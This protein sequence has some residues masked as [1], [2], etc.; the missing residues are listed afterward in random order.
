MKK[1]LLVAAIGVAGLLS[2][3]PLRTSCNKVVEL[4]SSY[5]NQLSDANLAQLVADVNKAVCGLY[6]TSVTVYLS[7]H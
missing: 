1:L 5:V 2:A 6:P 3:I 7:H 4:N